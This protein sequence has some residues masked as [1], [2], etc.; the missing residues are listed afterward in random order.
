MSYLLLYG[1]GGWSQRWEIP[2]GDDQLIS[3]EIS[4]VGQDTVSRLSVIDSQSDSVASLVIAW[5][6]VASAVIV[7]AAE[8]HPPD[9]ATGQYA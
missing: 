1:I 7:D 9:G 6:S 8:H 4:Q 2:A 3:D 5:R